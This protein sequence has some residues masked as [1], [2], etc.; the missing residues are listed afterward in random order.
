MLIG[1]A[2]RKRRSTFSRSVLRLG[3]ILTLFGTVGLAALS[4]APALASDACQ[5]WSTNEKHYRPWPSYHWNYIEYLG[6]YDRD[7]K[8]WHDYYSSHHGEKYS[9]VCNGY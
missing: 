9:K 1:G 3:A 2:G 7:G 8:H 4:P 5:S 6:H